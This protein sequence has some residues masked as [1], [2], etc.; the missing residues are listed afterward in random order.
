MSLRELVDVDARIVSVENL[1]GKVYKTAMIAP[2]IAQRAKPMQFVNIALGNSTDPLLRR[3]FSLSGIHPGSGIIEITFAVVGRG[4]QIMAG[5][6]PGQQAKVLGPLGNGLD[7]G[8]LCLD[9]GLILVAGGTGLAPLL[10]VASVAL[11]A[12]V[13]LKVFYG[14][15]SA[16]D[17]LDTGELGAGCQFY[18]ATDDGS[19]GTKGLVTDVFESYLSGL[20]T[21]DTGRPTV[22]ACGPKPM[23]RQIKRICK[24]Y[25]LPLVV[26]LEERMAC[27]YG[28]CQG[29]VVPSA[30][31]KH[32]YYRVC[33]DGPVFWADDIDLGECTT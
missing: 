15:R 17:L 22:I 7:L 1:R 19:A 29:C 12:Q 13:D 11:K 2:E 31:M 4:T 32:G 26:S 10:P 9:H 14:A 21:G 30:G 8:G 18:L 6:Q 5:W 23:L 20:G 33:T 3:P 24:R 25:G 16:D 28:V 27:G